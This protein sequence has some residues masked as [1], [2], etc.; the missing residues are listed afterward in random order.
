M[1]RKRFEGNASRENIGRNTLD[2][3][4]CCCKQVTADTAMYLAAAHSNISYEIKIN[5][6]TRSQKKT[7][8][9][10][11]PDLF[12]FVLFNSLQ[13]PQILPST[14]SSDSHPES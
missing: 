12:H 13:S 8:R 2:E 6:V 9:T 3:T 5:S 7:R 4:H 11:P 14:E 10:L 1:V